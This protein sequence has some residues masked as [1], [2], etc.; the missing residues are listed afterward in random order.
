MTP[1]AAHDLARR[2]ATLA[3]QRGGSV[4][5]V[6]G[7]RTSVEA[8]DALSAGLSKVMHLLHRA[9]EPGE[10]PYAGFLAWADAVVLAQAPVTV[11]SE[12][13]ATGGPVFIAESGRETT[14][15]RRLHASFIEAGHVKPL[16]D[17]L[18]PWPRSPLDE[19]GRA[20]A[21]IIRRFPLE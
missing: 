7:R 17:D 4:L 13:C 8:A 11:I 1:A 6:T 19:A 2:L 16:R 18:S 9:S 21:E 12:A 5:V 14:S 10:A 15:Q 20:A 3:R